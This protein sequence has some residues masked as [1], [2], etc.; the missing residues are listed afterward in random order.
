M[1]VDLRT[2]DLGSLAYLVGLA[3]NQRVTRAI[4]EA[5]FEGVRPALGFV[6]QHLIGAPRSVT[7]LGRLLGTSQQA[8]SKLVRDLVAHGYASQAPSPSDRR[9]SVIALSERGWELV[10]TART[11]RAATDQAMLDGLGEAERA[12]LRSLLLHAL[13]RLDG[14]D[15][16][17][18]RQVAPPG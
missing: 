3:F 10:E 6:I 14:V 2:L 11:L 15:A 16:V 9:A 18:R 1:N 5:G 13:D 17:L 4:A 12:A 7:E 8:A